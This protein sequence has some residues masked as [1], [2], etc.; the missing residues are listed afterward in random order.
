[1]RW[2]ASLGALLL[3]L[4][5]PAL[6]ADTQHVAL[7]LPEC[8]LP[9]IPASELRRAVALELQSEGLTLSPAGDLSASRDVQV[10]VEAD[11]SATDD[12]TLRAQH[13]ALHQSRT[14]RL[15]EL[16]I[17][18]R[19]RALALSI[20]ELASLL[21]R[22]ASPSSTEPAP[23]ELDEEP[24]SPA[25][26]SPPSKPATTATPGP[27]MESSSTPVSAAASPAQSV[28]VEPGFR[29]ALR[30]ELRFF[31]HT[32]LWGGRVQLERARF[33]YAIGL[34]AASKQAPTGG[35][36]TRLAHMSAAYAF[37]LLSKPR[38]TSIETG[39][40]LGFGYTFMSARAV[41]DA[42]ANDARDWYADL[43]W[44]LHCSTS[45]SSGAQLGFGAELGYARGPIGY[46]GDVVIAQTSGPFAS[47]MLEGSLLL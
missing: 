43:A 16:A 32:L 17:E 47:I 14:F 31:S 38:R 18:Q 45:L 19:P 3:G 8:E 33:R 15:S 27:P 34:L 23:R 25:N 44:S 40:R 2:L 7:S 36:S 11:C 29:L 6:A 39:P 5:L 12:L 4:P 35:V 20:A 46:A 26:P 13:G 22:P 1:M 30:P 9:A 28:G 21:L 10:R 37:S 24:P 41:P 42:T